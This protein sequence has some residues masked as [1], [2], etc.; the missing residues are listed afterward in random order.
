M[1]HV[2]QSSEHCRGRTTHAAAQQAGRRT[3]YKAVSV[4]GVPISEEAMPHYGVS[5]TPTL[6]AINKRGVVRVYSPAR[7]TEQR[8]ASEIE[9]VPR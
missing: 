8:L 4:A 9:R 6:I 7:L 2:V 5:A 1:A 3:P